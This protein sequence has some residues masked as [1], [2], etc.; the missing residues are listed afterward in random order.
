MFH[1][2]PWFSMTFL[3]FLPFILF[4]L[5]LLFSFCRSVPP[6][7][8][9]SFFS[10][11]PSYS[12]LLYSIPVL[13]PDFDNPFLVTGTGMEN[14]IPAQPCPFI[15]KDYEKGPLFFAALPKLEWPKDNPFVF[16]SS[17]KKRRLWFYQ[18]N[19]HSCKTVLCVTICPIHLLLWA[20]GKGLACDFLPYVVPRAV[21][22]SYIEYNTHLYTRIIQMYNVCLEVHDTL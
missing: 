6:E 3:L 21:I 1:D 18:L 2:F 16:W 15:V 7:F 8:L 22:C 9:R 13:I 17:I 5:F 11:E 12:Q 19:W 14:C 4:L 20:A 10:L